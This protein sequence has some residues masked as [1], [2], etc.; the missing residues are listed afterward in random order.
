MLLAAI[1]HA[2][3]CDDEVQATSVAHIEEVGEFTL[4]WIREDL[5]AQA[6]RPECPV[7]H[8]DDRT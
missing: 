5:D 7:P 8:C 2:L 3:G 1:T 6:P 4:A